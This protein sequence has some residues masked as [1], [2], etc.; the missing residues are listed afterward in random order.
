M[1]TEHFDEE[2]EATEAELKCLC[3]TSIGAAALLASMVALVFLSA[4]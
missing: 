1:N 4:F 2:Q 3:L